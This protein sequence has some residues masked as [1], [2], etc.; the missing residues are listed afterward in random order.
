MPLI[1]SVKS[2]TGAHIPKALRPA[3]AW[4]CV[5]GRVPTNYSTD[6]RAP[7]AQNSNTTKS[8]K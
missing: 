5:P 1:I 4:S 3:C 6:V 2:G 7:A 8:N